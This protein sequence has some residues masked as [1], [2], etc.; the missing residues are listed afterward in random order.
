MLTT[1]DK[2]NVE[3]EPA[4][5]PLREA[6]STRQN[7][8]VGIFIAAV[9]VLWQ[10]YSLF[11]P[12][13]QI[14]SP[15]DVAYAFFAMW[16]QAGFMTYAGYTVLHVV[17]SVALAFGLGLGIAILSYFFPVLSDAVYG[18]L[19]PFLNSFPGIGWALLALVWFG[20][21]SKSVI[22]TATAALLP[23]ALINIG[24]GLRELNRE[25]IEMSVSFTRQSR[26]RVWLVILP[27]LF[28]YL[29]A[30]LRLCFGVSWQI[31][32]IAELLCGAPGLGSI[33]NQA[34]AAYRTDMIFAVVILILIIVFVIDRW[35]GAS[36]QAR[37]GKAYNV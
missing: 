24:A 2:P 6:G 10:V 7:V 33:I 32:L 31:V 29:F 27:M 5:K 34:R 37:M 20:I 9:L 22:F 28:P 8:A 16:S 12:P 18:R 36:I 17:I 13:V 4:I 19:A 21:S 30:A 11:K 14:P 25:T 3:V 35:L 26:R 15:V 23:L 1:S